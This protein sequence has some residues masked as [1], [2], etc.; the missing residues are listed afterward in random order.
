MY[1]VVFNLSKS[2]FKNIWLVIFLLFVCFR[3]N[4]AKKDNDF[5]Y[6]ES[7]PGLDTLV[8]VKGIQTAL[9]SH[10][11]KMILKTLEIII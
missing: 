7:V 3:Y 1:A 10:I 5:I 8:A 2:L 11:S 6:H 4:S 9:I